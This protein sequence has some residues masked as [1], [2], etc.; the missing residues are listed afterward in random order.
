MRSVNWF[1][2]NGCELVK[3]NIEVFFGVYSLSNGQPCRGCNCKDTC[4]AWPKVNETPTAS[5]PTGHR[6][7][8]CQS[9]LNMVKVQRRGGK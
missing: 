1:V 7:P 3:P 2:D 4:P 8:R 5:N 6:C 9:P